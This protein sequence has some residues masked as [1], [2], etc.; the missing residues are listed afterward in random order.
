MTITVVLVRAFR[1]LRRRKGLGIGLV[2]SLLALSVVGN[3]ASFWI[4]DGA[5]AGLGFRDALWYSVI[6]ITT[7]G[8]GDYSASSTGARIGTLVFIVGLG[9]TTFTMVLGMVVDWATNLSLKGR[10]GMGRAIASD[11][12]LLVNFPSASRV[13]SLIRELQTDPDYPSCEVV[14]VTDHS[15]YD[16]AEIVRHSKMVLDTRNATRNVRAGRSRVHKL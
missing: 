15:E 12:I 1:R 3:A 2:L 4:F 14:I 6:S 8:Y 11:H 5:D 13:K 10:L 7:I 9:L 16:Y